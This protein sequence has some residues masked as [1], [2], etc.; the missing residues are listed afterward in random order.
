MLIG[1]YVSDGADAA[2]ATKL[3]ATFQS[4]PVLGAVTVAGIAFFHQLTTRHF[5]LHLALGT[6]N[7]ALHRSLTAFHP[8]MPVAARTARPMESAT[9]SEATAPRAV[10]D[11]SRP[12]S[13][14]EIA[15]T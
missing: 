15:N 11:T 8:G 5:S 7:F 10:S 12:T 2:A 4:G 6:S 1:R 9:S 14:V 3:L 13:P